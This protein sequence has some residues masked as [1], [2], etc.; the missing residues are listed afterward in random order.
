[1]SQDV[2]ATLG[3]RQSSHGDFMHNGRIMQQL[4]ND[5]RA[6]TGWAKLQP[7]QAEALDMILHKIGRILCGNPDFADHWHDIAGYATLIENI[8][9]KGVSHPAPEFNLTQPKPV[10]QSRTISSFNPN[11]ISK[12]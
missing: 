11:P 10:S 9:T 3:L 1:M 12:A 6:T 7:H 8:I 4:K 5:A 2:Q